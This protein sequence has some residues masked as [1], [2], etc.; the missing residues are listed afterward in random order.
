VVAERGSH[1]ELL[2][3]DGLY[4][5]MWALQATERQAAP[6][7]S[8][9]RMEGDA[10]EPVAAETTGPTAADTIDRVTTDALLR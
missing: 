6:E 7:E 2:A 9:D 10:G 4:A 1:A 5:R 3:R 8:G